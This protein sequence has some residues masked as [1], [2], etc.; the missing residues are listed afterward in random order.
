MT[1]YDNLMNIQIILLVGDG[2]LQEREVV[3]GRA[4]SAGTLSPWVIAAHRRA[5]PDLRERF[6]LWKNCF[7]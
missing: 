1:G 5:M 2:Y 3:V 6:I 4:L 7:L